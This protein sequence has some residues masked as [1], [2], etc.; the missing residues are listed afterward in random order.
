M[1]LRGKYPYK[2]NAEIKEICEA[3]I[4][5]YIFEDECTDIIKYMYNIEDSETLLQKLKK[6]FLYGKEKVLKEN[7]KLSREEQSY[8]EQEKEKTKIEYVLFQKV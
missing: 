8:M 2:N 7:R 3:K 1:Y 6:H 4:I 5:G